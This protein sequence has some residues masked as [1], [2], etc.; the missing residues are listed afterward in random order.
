VRVLVDQIR[1]PNRLPMR[2]I[3]RSRLTVRASCRA[4]D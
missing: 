1:N 4:N 3:I 2:L